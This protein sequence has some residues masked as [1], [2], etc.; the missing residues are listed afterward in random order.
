MPYHVEEGDEAVRTAADAFGD[1]M[2]MLLHKSLFVCAWAFTSTNFASA[3]APVS[4]RIVCPSALPDEAL[5]IGETINGWIPYKSSP[6]LLNSA[7][8]TC[9]RPEELADLAGFDTVKTKT[10][11]IDTYPLPL[12]HQHGIWMKCGYGTFNEVTLHKQLDD[13]IR[14]CKLTTF[15]GEP[16]VIDIVCT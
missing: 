4:Q 8:P 16:V 7:A 14:Q 15:N 3:A 5:H 2:S 13:R 11:R 6:L 12:P 9:G 10:A 1:Q